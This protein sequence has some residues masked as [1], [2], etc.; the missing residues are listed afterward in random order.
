MHLP[1]SFLKIIF[2]GVTGCV[3]DDLLVFWCLCFGM[4]FIADA[5]MVVYFHTGVDKVEQEGLFLLTLS[6]C[7][8]SC[9]FCR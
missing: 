6:L 4:D 3:T 2:D 9:K 8:T 5:V 1:W 7:I